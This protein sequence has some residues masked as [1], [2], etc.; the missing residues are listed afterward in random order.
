VTE[1]RIDPFTRRSVVIAPG[2]RGIGATRPGGL[3]AQDARCPFCPGHEADTEEAIAAWP[4]EGPWC[5]R[6]VNNK[7]PIRSDGGAHE[8]VIESPDHDADLPDLPVDHA[9]VVLRAYR[10]RARALEGRSGVAAVIVFRNRG[11]RAGSSQPHPHAQIVALDWV[12]AELALRWSVAEEHYAEH[13]E[14]V[15]DTALWQE[16]ADGARVI[17]S[18][19]R[20]LVHCPYAP[21]RAF[22]VRISARARGG[23]ASADDAELDALAAHLVDATSRLRRVMSLADYNLIVRSSP[24]SDPAPGWHLD[25]LPRTG[26]DAGF[27]LA[28]GEMIIIVAPEEAARLLRGA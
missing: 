14:R 1:R 17:A 18:D 16:E 24:S 10:D 12:P 9:G 27:E 7:Y 21:S 13:G 20:F 19:E 28:S 22:E 26:G 11:R 8:V 3:P 23:F 6:V 25:I 2:R 4:S 5:V 15:H